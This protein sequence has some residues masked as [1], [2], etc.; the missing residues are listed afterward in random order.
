MYIIYGS[1][2]VCSWWLTSLSSRWLV[3]IPPLLLT[4]PMSRGWFLRSCAV[5]DSSHRISS[6]NTSRE[7]VRFAP[8]DRRESR[9]HSVRSLCGGI[10]PFLRFVGLT[11]R[12][13]STNWYINI[14]WFCLDIYNTIPSL[15]NIYHDPSIFRAIIC[16]CK[17][18]ISRSFLNTFFT[19]CI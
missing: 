7:L 17:H 2:R 19:L 5:I 11:R 15:I 4:P 9:Q 1:A 6:E 10:N 12:I 14:I 18:N 3:Q 16:I 8:V 13:K